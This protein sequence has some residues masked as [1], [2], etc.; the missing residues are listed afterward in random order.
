MVDLKELLESSETDDSDSS[1]E[2]GSDSRSGNEEEDD[3]DS[4]DVRSG[5]HSLF[6]ES[7]S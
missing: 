7:R 4:I 3:D 5:P 6:C 1:S 2:S